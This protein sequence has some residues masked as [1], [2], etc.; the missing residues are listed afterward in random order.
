M[1]ENKNISSIRQRLE[2]SSELKN[3]VME[4]A[5]KLEAGRKTF[6]SE[7]TTTDHIQINKEQIQMNAYNTKET[8]KIKRHFPIA[9]ISA[10]AC[11]AIVIGIAAVNMNEK[12]P[13][14]IPMTSTDS[15]ATD[16]QTVTNDDDSISESVMTVTDA[17]YGTYTITD[18]DR[19]AVIDSLV[20]KAKTCQIWDGGKVP[21]SRIL[22]YVI[23]GKKRTVKISKGQMLTE[24]LA[25]THTWEDW[26]A[27]LCDVVTVDGMSYAVCEMSP[28]EPLSELEWT[29]NKG[30]DMFFQ[31][32]NDD[33]YDDQHFDGEYN[34]ETTAG[35]LRDIIKD[36]RENGTPI[37]NTDDYK[38]WYDS[39][40]TPAWKTVRFT[41]DCNLD[42]CYYDVEI[43]SDSNQIAV[44]EYDW[45]D[46]KTHYLLY[47]DTQD[48][49]ARFEEVFDSFKD[50]P[51]S[52]YWFEGSLD[53][54]AEKVEIPE[55]FDMTEEQAVEAL[56]EA[57]LNC[58]VEYRFDSTEKG[59]V[60][61]W[62]DK[63]ENLDGIV[64]EGTYIPIIVSLGEYDGPNEMVIVEYGTSYY[65]SK[66]T[67]LE[68][69]V[70]EGLK[71]SYTFNI[72]A[73]ESVMFKDTFDSTNDD[74]SVTFDTDAEDKERFVIY[75][76]KDGSAEENLIRYATYE[77]DYAS[78]TWT[79]IGELNTD[80]LLNA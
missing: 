65:P 22:E 37:F 24:S 49:T 50:L 71:G 45:H 15:I 59:H 78:E 4:R 73:G 42:G 25:K 7:K 43:Y 74:K 72:Y 23:D 18:K 1:K 63:S 60:C 29:T 41:C 9:A 61:G 11:A 10:A 54:E 40:Q 68:V 32:F 8:A 62:Y 5:A 36:I 75:A 80:E 48:W 34:D 30:E 14:T 26:H 66:E 6:G 39:D 20:E 28:D 53:E 46:G 27:E 47:K 17:E 44:E 57:G 13:K 77:F 33:N 69:P 35:K 51:E 21:T 38:E 3:R 31:I 64:E 67:K 12:K 70:P 56:K 58:I 79:L 16:D 52:D 55:I 76:E 19:I 2:P